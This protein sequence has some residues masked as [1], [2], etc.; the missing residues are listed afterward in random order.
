MK[1][2]TFFLS[3]SLSLLGMKISLLHSSRP[4]GRIAPRA[5]EVG[6]RG[7]HKEQ[8]IRGRRVFRAGLGRGG[9]E[10]ERYLDEDGES[11]PYGLAVH[12]SA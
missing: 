4:F 7:A 2:Y 3:L 9:E 8:R 11:P 12:D 10:E 5:T 1:R 6:R